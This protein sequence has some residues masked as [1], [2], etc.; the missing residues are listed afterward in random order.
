[1]KYWMTCA[2]SLLI[3]VGACL[4]MF[5]L[6]YHVIDKEDELKA[7][8]AQIREDS[9]AIH[10]LEAEWATRND[11]DRLAKLITSETAWQ[12]LAAGQI[13]SEE[14]LPVKAAPVP[15]SKPQFNPDPEVQP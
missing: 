9:R 14:D 6:K 8:H 11:P 7:I 10:M 1:M 3:T 12:P 4:M 5:I 13:Q 15:R 2:L